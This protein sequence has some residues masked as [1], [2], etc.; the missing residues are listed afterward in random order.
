MF[1]VIV[2]KGQSFLRMPRLAGPKPRRS[3]N[4]RCT[5][6]N[7]CRVPVAAICSVSPSAIDSKSAATPQQMTVTTMSSRTPSTTDQ[8]Y[9]TQAATCAAGNAAQ[10][11]S[12]TQT[13]SV[14]MANSG[15]LKSAAVDW[16]KVGAGVY[17]ACFRAKDGA[18][19]QATGLTVVVTGSDV[20][21]PRAKFPC[22]SSSRV[23]FFSDAA[24]PVPEKFCGSE[25]VPCSTFEACGCDALRWHISRV[26]NA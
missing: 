15:G 23:A 22:M 20:D 8:L 10:A 4:T 5:K 16:S 24:T 14:A 25:A 17:Q 9:F 6:S 7:P 13:A 3:L 19:W 2:S 18:A 26:S 1:C 21:M 11:A 12:A